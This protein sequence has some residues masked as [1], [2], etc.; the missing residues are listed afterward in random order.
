MW[1]FYRNSCLIGPILSIFVLKEKKDYLIL[2]LVGAAPTIGS[3]IISLI[4][5]VE[6]KPKEEPKNN[7]IDAHYYDDIEEPENE[8]ENI[9]GIEIK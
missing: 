2:Y 3:L 6:I 7:I 9:K 1:Y 4:L 8:E 5:K